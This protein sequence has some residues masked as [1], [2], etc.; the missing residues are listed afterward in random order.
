MADLS[1]PLLDMVNTKLTETGTDCS[2]PHGPKL[3]PM[4]LPK[5]DA[6][7]NSLPSE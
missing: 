4:S 3:A 7:T 1:T 5:S 2:D 6:K